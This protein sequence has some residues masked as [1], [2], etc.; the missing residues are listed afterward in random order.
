MGKLSKQKP[1]GDCKSCHKGKG[2]KKCHV[3]LENVCVC[4]I[5]V[6][7]GSEFELMIDIFKHLRR[8]LLRWVD[9]SCIAQRLTNGQKPEK[10]E[11]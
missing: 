2:L 6:R 3:Y 1:Q 11:F 9:P 8:L 10:S 7:G 5:G 4:K